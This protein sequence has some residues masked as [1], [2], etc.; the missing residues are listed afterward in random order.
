[1]LH[2]VHL[3][4]DQSSLRESKMNLRFIPIIT[5]LAILVALGGCGQKGQLYLPDEKQTALFFDV[6]IA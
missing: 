4:G 2:E 1:M 3:A 5:L 6:Y